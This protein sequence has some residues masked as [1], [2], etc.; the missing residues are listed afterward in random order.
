M[1]KKITIDKGSG[2]QIKERVVEIDD[3]SKAKEFSPAEMAGFINLSVNQYIQDYV[4]LEIQHRVLKEIFDSL[5]G[6]EKMDE[7]SAKMTEVLQKQE[8]MSKQIRHHRQVR[9]EI[10]D[11]RFKV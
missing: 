5:R 9:D 3:I 2:K 11:G 7:V 8:G 1:D 10:G 6:K 4:S